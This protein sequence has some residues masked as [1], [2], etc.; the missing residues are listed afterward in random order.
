MAKEAP[1]VV[2][3][4]AFW[5][6]S[7]DMAMGSFKTV[8][9]DNPSTPRSVPPSP[10]KKRKERGG[11]SPQLPGSQ[12]ALH[13]DL[14]TL[15]PFGSRA[16]HLS[17]SH[18]RC[19]IRSPLGATWWRFQVLEGCSDWFDTEWGEPFLFGYRR[20][21]S[22]DIDRASLSRNGVGAVGCLLPQSQIWRD[23]SARAWTVRGFLF[24]EVDTESSV[25]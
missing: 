16:S 21:A 11:T 17:G 19:C 2:D 14:L 20:R 22:L 10:P 13:D 1:Q 12:M 15:L 5:K 8:V 18:R 25:G 6:K 9:A 4:T 3:F 24:F 23:I 7:A